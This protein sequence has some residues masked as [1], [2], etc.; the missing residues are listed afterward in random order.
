MGK[1]CPFLFTQCQAIHARSLLP[2]QDSPSVKITYSASVECPVSMTAVMSAL[3][4]R[5]TETLTGNCF[6][7]DQPCSI[8]VIES[9]FFLS[10]I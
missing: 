5:K 3:L 1:K 6:E 2:C 10:H 4:V 8:P 7:F 9:L